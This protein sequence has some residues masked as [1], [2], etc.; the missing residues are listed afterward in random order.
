MNQLLS[1]AY[2]SIRK[3]STVELVLLGVEYQLTV[4]D[5]EKSKQKSYDDV[6]LHFICVILIIVEYVIMQW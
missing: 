6:D 3:N 5:F 1:S 4:D 2:L